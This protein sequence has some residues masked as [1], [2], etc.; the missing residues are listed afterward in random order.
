[1]LKLLLHDE[2]LKPVKSH[3]FG[4]GEQGKVNTK[5]ITTKKHRPIS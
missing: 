1:M 3:G 4:K 2:A 5:K